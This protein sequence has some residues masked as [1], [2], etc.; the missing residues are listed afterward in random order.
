MVS[1]DTIDCSVVNETT[2]NGCFRCRCC[3]H[4]LGVV[5]QT[6]GMLI[7]SMAGKSG[8]MHGTYQVC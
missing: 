5:L 7:E 4:H 3:C 6:I 8:A 2:T 1:F